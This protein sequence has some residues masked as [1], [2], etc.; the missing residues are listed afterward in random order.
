MI[1]KKTLL[2]KMDQALQLAKQT[3]N[4]EVMR[5]QIQKVHVLAEL[6]IEETSMTKMSTQSMGVPNQ[7]ETKK[8]VTPEQVEHQTIDHQ[9]DGTSIFDF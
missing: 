8:I 3:S 9:D 2:H 1:S 5:Q 6:I 7:I 4:E